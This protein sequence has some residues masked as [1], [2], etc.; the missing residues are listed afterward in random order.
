MSNVNNRQVAYGEECPIVKVSLEDQQ[1]AAVGKIKR[2]EVRSK[3]GI[4]EI[5]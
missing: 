4:A 1:R 3:K 5:K 2:N